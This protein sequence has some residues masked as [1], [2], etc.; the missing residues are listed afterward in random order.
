MSFYPV[1]RS[2][3]CTRAPSL[4]PSSLLHLLKVFL[5][6]RLKMRN[7]PLSPLVATISVAHHASLF[8]P[9]LRCLAGVANSSHL[10]TEGARERM[11]ET[12]NVFPIYYSLLSVPWGCPSGFRI[13]HLFI[14]YP[15]EYKDGQ[16]KHL[17]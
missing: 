11:N 1:S 14:S 2:L 16:D 15:W 8:T 12:V 6:L 7:P 3:S 17:F 13:I 4:P 9:D 10:F 5:S